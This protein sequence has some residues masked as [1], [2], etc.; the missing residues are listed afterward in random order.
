[1]ATK[2]QR[3]MTKETGN[4]PAHHEYRKSVRK[5]RNN[6][7]MRKRSEEQNQGE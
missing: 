4:L 3:K 7:G 6:S 2:Q 5:A 1:M